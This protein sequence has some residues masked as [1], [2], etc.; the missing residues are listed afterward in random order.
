M[1]SALAIILEIG[2]GEFDRG[3]PFRLRVLDQQKLLGAFDGRLPPAPGLATAYEQWKGLYDSLGMTSL[4][5]V[6]PAQV[7]NVSVADQCQAAAARLKQAIN[8]WLNHSDLRSIERKLLRTL[9]QAESLRFFIQT[10]H[11]YLQRLPWQVWDLLEECYPDTEVILSAAY[12]PTHQKFT[13]P[14]RI[15]AIEGDTAGTQAELNLAPIEAIPGTQITLI[16]QPDAATLRQNLWDK[17]WDILFFMGHSRSVETGGEIVLNATETLSLEMLHDALRNAVRNGLKLAIFNSCD[18]VGIAQKLADL[19]IPYTIVMREQV[20]DTI[21]QSFL[22]TFLQSFA[23][24]SSLRDAVHLARCQLREKH[25]EF[26]FA[27]WLPVIYQNPAAPEITYPK[28]RPWQRWR[29]LAGCVG[30]AFATTSIFALQN[31]LSQQAQLTQEYERRTSAGEDLLTRRRTQEKSQ[32]IAAFAAANYPLAIQKF[33]QSLKLDPY[34]AETL[35]YLNNANARNSGK[36]LYR[37]ALGVPIDRN[38]NIA[39]EMMG[40]TAHSQAQINQQSDHAFAIEI[41]IANDENNPKI[42]QNIATRLTHDSR[43]VAVIGHNSSNATIPALSIYNQKK[44]VMITPTS[45]SGKISGQGPYTFQMVPDIRMISRTLVNHA[46][47]RYANRT[48]AICADSASRDNQDYPNHFA[49]QI[50]QENPNAKLIV[51]RC[52]LYESGFDPKAKLAELQQAGAEVLLLAPHI[53]RISRA[54]AAAKAAKLRQMPLLGS[55]TFYTSQTLKEGNRDLLGMVIAVPWLPNAKDGFSTTARKQLGQ[56]TWRI[57]LSYDALQTIH[58]GLTFRPT[59]ST[60]LTGSKLTPREKIHQA[61]NHPKFETQGI[62]GFVKFDL[63]ENRHGD[64][65]KTPQ[66]LQLTEVKA[67]AEAP[68]GVNFMPIP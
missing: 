30:V 13:L 60:T 54:I 24:G 3:F 32:A 52:D 68:Y 10:Q 59:D 55:A 66:L 4:I 61:L 40:G 65:V 33:Q 67:V 58:A 50:R 62:T 38:P 7:T 20:P 47:K 63:D 21:A 18:G 34:D 64:R 29:L 15:L 1:K 57:A 36:P 43:I 41:V 46:L 28:S 26:P 31:H 44:L 45:F 9:P 51:D 48:I 25:L 11:P 49:S 23:R 27:A 39:Q 35:I 19:K 37:V 8:A 5:S 56:V 12:E 16:K 53:D 2:E 42:V 14:V 6:T 22:K 17:N